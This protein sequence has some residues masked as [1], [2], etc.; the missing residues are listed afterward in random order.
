MADYSYQLSDPAKEVPLMN[1]E[2]STKATKAIMNFYEK[3]MYKESHEIV[4]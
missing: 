3:Q 4:D 1:F 2:T